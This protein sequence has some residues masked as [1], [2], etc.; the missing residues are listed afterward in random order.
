[1]VELII[2]VIFIF[3]F[4][5]VLIILFRKIPILNTLP[6]NGTTGIGKHRIVLNIGSQVN[7]VFIFFRKQI[8]WHKILSWVKVMTLKIET[9]V[10]VLLHKIRKNAQEIDKDLKNRK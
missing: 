2:S 10:D 7:E 8:F 4:G 9:R 6:Q 3:S 5:G 1:M